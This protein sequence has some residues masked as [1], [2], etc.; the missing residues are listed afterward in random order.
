MLTGG[1]APAGAVT[2]IETGPNTAIFELATI[3]AGGLGQG[4]D[5]VARSLTGNDCKAFNQAAALGAITPASTSTN[6]GLVTSGQGT[7]TGPFTVQ[8]VGGSPRQ[9]M[10]RPM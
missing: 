5:S 4:V 9:R 2:F 10:L 7:S 6:Y 1:D 8:T 3:T